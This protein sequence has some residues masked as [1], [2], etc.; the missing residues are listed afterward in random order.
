MHCVDPACVGPYS[1]RARRVLVAAH[2]EAIGRQAAAVDE[3][4]LLAGLAAVD[5]LAGLAILAQLG[6]S[7]ERLHHALESILPAVPGRG[8]PRP[9]RRRAGARSLPL[10]EHLQ[11]T[12]TLAEEEARALGLDYVGV[13]H[14]VLAL[15]R[16]GTG[17]AHEV[18]S[19]TR[20][21]RRRGPRRAPAAPGGTASSTESVT[22]RQALS[23]APGAADRIREGLPS[24]GPRVTGRSPCSHQRARRTWPGGETGGAADGPALPARRRRRPPRGGGGR[25][26]GRGLGA[27]RARRGG[28]QRRRPRPSRLR[29]RLPADRRPR[30]R[31]WRAAPPRP[32][33]SAAAA[34]SGRPLRPAPT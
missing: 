30:R 16:R 26:R 1:A 17:P 15:L 6:V 11:R 29:G 23:G 21:H 25:R 27:E 20:R 33:S 10:G 8:R 3:E 14:F 9:R 7:R 34:E 31:R 28:G 18:L 2:E 19:R 12:L 4:H 22:A 13:E 24:G 5:G 32:T